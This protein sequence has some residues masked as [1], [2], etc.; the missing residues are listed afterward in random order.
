VAAHALTAATIDGDDQPRVGGVAGRALREAQQLPQAGP[1]ATGWVTAAG[2][3]RRRR[4]PA[5]AGVLPHR[6]PTTR[7]HR[8]PSVVPWVAA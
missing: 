4:P 8:E 2:S 6:A 5:G 1:C 3:G 7:P